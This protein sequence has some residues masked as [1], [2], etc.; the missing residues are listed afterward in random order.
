MANNRL[1]VDLATLD[2][3]RTPVKPNVD[4]QL[5]EL[6]IENARLMSEVDKQLAIAERLTGEVDYLRAALANALQL[7]QAAIE[8][9]VTQIPEAQARRIG[10]FDRLLGRG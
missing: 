5:T 2:P 6:R 7:R 3:A 4:R 9:P 10:W 1:Y 8:A